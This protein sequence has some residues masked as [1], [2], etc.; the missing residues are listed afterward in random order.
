MI[1]DRAAGKT[2]HVSIRVGVELFE[3]LETLADQ[4]RETVSQCA[5][6]LLDDG[7]ASRPRDAIDEAIAALQLLQSNIAATTGV[8]TTDVES[9]PDAPTVR[10]VN[11]L[12]AKTNLSRLLSDVG[13]GE[14]VVITH[15]GAPRARLIPV[16]DLESA[17]S[18]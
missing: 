13:R 10:T 16:D 9:S 12:N 3:R 15:A 1:D 8:E 2:R 6:R 18:E 11:I 4:R 17:G 7:L 14:H 5:R